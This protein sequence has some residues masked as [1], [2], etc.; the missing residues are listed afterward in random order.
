M[1]SQYFKD[2]KNL[3]NLVLSME[4]RV[5]KLDELNAAE[6]NPR[7]IEKENLDGLSES[8]VSFGYLQ[9]IVVNIRDN[10]NVI[11]GGHQRYKILILKGIK[12]AECVI[13]DVDDITEKTINISLNNPEIAGRWNLN[14]LEEQ[15]AEIHELIPNFEDLQLSTLESGLELNSE[16]FDDFDQEDEEPEPKTKPLEDI[17]II[18]LEFIPEDYELFLKT[19]GKEEISYKS[20]VKR[21]QYGLKLMKFIRRSL[22]NE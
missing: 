11:V 15:L 1:E 9:P 13:I 2:Q 10:K 17:F 16:D 14:K 6:Y 19:V 21:V 12:K 5:F 20:P 3:D 4:T 22:E 7:E 8:L 18:E